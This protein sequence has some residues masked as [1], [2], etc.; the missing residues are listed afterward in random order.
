MGTRSHTTVYDDDGT[1]LVT[2]YQQYDGYPE[3]VGR[4]LATFLANIEIVNGFGTDAK[5]GEVANGPECLAAQLVAHLK[6]D[7]G[8]AYVTTPGDQGQE[9]E[10][11]IHVSPAGGFLSD[12]P[13]SIRLVARQVYDGGAVLFDGTPAE[14]LATYNKEN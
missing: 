14:F 10:Y 12:L 7:V 9:Y 11:E 4:E 5:L 6:T 8:G 13:G 2:I 3:G 1:R